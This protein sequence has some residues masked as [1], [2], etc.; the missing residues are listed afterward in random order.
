MGGLKSNLILFSC[1]LAKDRR[2]CTR[3]RYVQ[4]MSLLLSCLLC[5]VTVVVHFELLCRFYQEQM[6]TSQR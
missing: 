5:V 4:K 3:S 1:L 2:E 6:Q